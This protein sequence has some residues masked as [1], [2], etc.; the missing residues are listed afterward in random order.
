MSEGVRMVAL[1]ILAHSQSIQSP[2]H[3]ALEGR[4]ELCQ[5]VQDLRHGDG[6][7]YPVDK[8]KLLGLVDMVEEYC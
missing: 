5:V 6:V 1:R 2:R 7:V 4:V 8:E 3:R